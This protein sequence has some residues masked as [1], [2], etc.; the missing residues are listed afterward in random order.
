MQ[1]AV[2]LVCAGLV[3]LALSVPAVA[4]GTVPGGSTP[5]S[6]MSP[7]VT[8]PTGTSVVNYA[9]G[10]EALGQAPPDSGTSGIGTETV[11]VGLG[12]AGAA[13]LTIGV[14]ANNNNDNNDSVSP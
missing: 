12:L 13:G 6:T 5:P 4:Q 11:L 2:T 14:I 1:R 9:N 3:S 10:L 7:S 8:Q